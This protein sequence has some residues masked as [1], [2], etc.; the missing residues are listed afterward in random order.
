MDWNQPVGIEYEFTK[1]ASERFQMFLGHYD[2]RVYLNDNAY[3]D[4]GAGSLSC[5]KRVTMVSDDAVGSLGSIGRFCEFGACEVMAL[6]A[7]DNDRAVNIGFGCSPLLASL[8]KQA[9]R[10]WL[11]ATGPISIGDNVVIST[12]AQVLPGVKVATG[13]VIGAGAVV[14]KDAEAFGI[15]VGVPARRIK[16]RPPCQPWWD[17]SPAY[18]AQN[19][20]TLSQLATEH[21]QHIYRQDRPRFVYRRKPNEISLIGFTEGEEI[22]PLPEA[23]EKVRAYLAQAFKPEGPYYW[24]ADCWSD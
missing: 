13:C 8:S 16:E 23:P 21:G 18:M 17:F 19:I 20:A 2:A 11:K 14:T 6:G 24:L 7:H 9:G 22:R 10:G 5:E 4:V 3:I 1:E 15:Y 12:G